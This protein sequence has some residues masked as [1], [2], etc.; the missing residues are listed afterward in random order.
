VG[1]SLYDLNFIGNNCNPVKV[2]EKRTF[3]LSSG[4]VDITIALDQGVYLAGD[5][6]KISLTLD[7]STSKVISNVTVSLIQT[8]QLYIYGSK[9]GEAQ[10]NLGKIS[11]GTLNAKEIKNPNYKL[12]IPKTVPETISKVKIGQKG[13]ET[14]VGK[15]LQVKYSLQLYGEVTLGTDVNFEVP[16]YI[17]R[18]AEKKEEKKVI[19]ESK[20]YNK[21]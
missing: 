8:V 6:M 18:R 17:V 1:G 2:N 21:K 10:N 16:I 3:L 11:L 12:Q 14:T 4:M 20:L 7:N 13:K 9:Y 19:H 15:I 5:L